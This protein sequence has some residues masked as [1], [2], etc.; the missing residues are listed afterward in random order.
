MDNNFGFGS[1]FGLDLPKETKEGKKKETKTK[2][3]TGSSKTTASKKVE[4]KYKMP[5]TVHAEWDD[6][7]ISDIEDLTL[8]QISDKIENSDNLELIEK[9]G[10]LFAIV[11]TGSNVDD[12]KLSENSEDV[13]VFVAGDFIEISTCSSVD[14]LEKAVISS[15]PELTDMK[16]SFG[17][18]SDKDNCYNLR[19]TNSVDLSLKLSDELKIG[20]LG[21]YEKIKCY[22]PKMLKEIVAEFESSHSWMSKVD[23][24]WFW[25]E[26]SQTIIAQFAKTKSKSKELIIKLPVYI[27]FLHDAG[28]LN[29]GLTSDLFD[30]KEYVSTKEILKVVDKYF[31]DI[32]KESNTQVTYVEPVN[33]VCIMR[34]GRSKGCTNSIGSYDTERNTY[35]FFL[36]KIPFAILEEIVQFFKESLPNEALVDIIYD[37]KSKE[38]SLIKPSSTTTSVSV[39]WD[40]MSILAQLKPTQSVVCEIHSHNTMHAFFSSIDNGDEIQPLVYGVIGRLNSAVEMCFRARIGREFY[41]ILVSDIFM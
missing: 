5:V 40:E 30:G 28:E 25:C 31:P 22:K 20:F 4:K 34:Q 26:K 33:T 27:R 10:E 35:N 13:K 7:T 29:N 8:K 11:K 12:K 14:E 41:P 1:Y 36:P 17:K 24:D 23:V 16:L 21:N 2:K 32:Y 37:K 18:V 15:Y 6:I 39:V 38:Y 3:T 19:L 9:D